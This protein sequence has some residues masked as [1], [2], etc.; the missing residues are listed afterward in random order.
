[1]DISEQEVARYWDQN[2]VLWADHVRK[3]WDAYRE[4]L[5][6]PA[7]LA[8]IGDLHGKTVLD[9]GCGEG[10][11]TRLLARSGAR[12][13]GVDISPRMIELA[14]LEEQREPLGICYELASFSDLSIFADASFDVVVSFMA[15]MDGPD[16]ESAAKEIFRLLRP[17]GELIFSITHPCF[18]TK[19]L[20]WIRDE[21]DNCIKLTV[22]E[23]FAD[24]PWV[25]HW[26]F[27]KAPVED[28]ELFAVPRF[29]RTLSEYLNTLIGAGFML[30][31][32]QE[33]RPSE[34]ACQQH[35]WLQ[36]WRDHAALF[37]YIRVAKPL[38]NGGE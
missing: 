17:G 29:P 26:R 11:N 30:K 24:Q 22:A 23:Y 35:P 8:F 34:E 5:N 20:G 1:V 14:R 28:V 2:A 15:L 3:G 9:A 16:F 37:L 33:P 27:S 6:N 4:H 38:D 13:V 25:E 36:R 21:E 18:A 7:M 31:E 32:I 19:G 12:M 10:Y